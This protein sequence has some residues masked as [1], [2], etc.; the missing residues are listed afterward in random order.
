MLGGFAKISHTDIDG[1]NK[2]LKLLFGVDDPPGHA[3]ALDCGAGEWS[4]KFSLKF[5]SV[6]LDSWTYRTLCRCYPL[7]TLAAPLHGFFLF[8]IL[9]YF[10]AKN[11]KIT[12]II[13]PVIFYILL[14][15]ILKTYADNRL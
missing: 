9:A 6:F 5:K 12:S 13:N 11:S 14:Y 8:R 4:L 15:F 1:S 7:V 10:A 3:R 2:F